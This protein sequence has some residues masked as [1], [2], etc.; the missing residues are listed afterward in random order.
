[1]IRVCSS[2][3]D[4]DYATTGDLMMLLFQA[5]TTA[6]VATTGEID[7]LGR[8]VRRASAW[9]EAYVG[10]PL[11]LQVYSESLPAF[12]G[13]RLV[14]SR[15]PVVAVLRLFDSTATCEATEVLSSEYV[16]EDRVAGFLARD[17]GF[18]WTLTERTGAGDF[19]LGLAGY[20]QPGQEQRPWLVEYAAGY[21]PI[22]GVTTSS[23][24]WS[25]AGPGG[26]TTTGQTLPE[27]VRQA[28]AIRA[29]EF[30]ANPL[31]V[32]SRRVGDLAVDYATAG[33]TG[34][35]RAVS[36]AERM[37]EPYRRLL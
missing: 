35:G 24:N 16:V 27:D 31:G 3:T 34:T 28:V 22:G 7:H 25:T 33:P 32:S 13:R 23:P 29:A 8:L 18:P 12:G 6:V 19:S 36:A 5:T 9:A 37:L 2:S 17:Q 30:Q 20:R 14:V 11:G 26:S 1:M 10:Y 21:V 4:G 15:T